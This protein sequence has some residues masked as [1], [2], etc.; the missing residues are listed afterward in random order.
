[1][2]TKRTP[3]SHTHYYINKFCPHMMT[4]GRIRTSQ[5]G[6][7]VALLV[8]RI[9]PDTQSSSCDTLDQLRPGRDVP[10]QQEQREW[11]GCRRPGGQP[12]VGHQAHE[13]ARA[14]LPRA[15]A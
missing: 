2:H 9:R 13:R 12:E 1:M 8:S 11:E 15:A 10:A 5:P 7:R 3:D 6:K 14:Q 4:C